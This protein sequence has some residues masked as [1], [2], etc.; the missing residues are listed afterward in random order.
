MIYASKRER[1]KLIRSVNHCID[2]MTDEMHYFVTLT[3]DSFVTFNKR[4][5][6]DNYQDVYADNRILKRMI[7]HEFY[8]NPD[9]SSIQYLFCV[10]KHKV[11]KR[12]H[13]HL[14]LSLP[15]HEFVRDKYKSMFKIYPEDTYNH[16]LSKSISRLK[17]LN[18]YVI[19]SAYDV[20]SLKSYC[21]KEIRN[22][23][24]KESNTNCIDWQN[25]TFTRFDDIR[26]P[27]H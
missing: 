10:E 5:F 9:K 13:T 25:S 11:T 27:L 8:R 17:R 3:Y 4:P 21:T 12:L 14:L 1:E 7:N 15:H 6:Y 24:K 19:K 23:G 26:E 2:S 18:R 22:D 16:I 20:P